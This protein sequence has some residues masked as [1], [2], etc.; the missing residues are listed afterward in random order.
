M[1]PNMQAGSPLI[2]LKG[3]DA[4][5]QIPMLTAKCVA[6]TTTRS[7][8]VLGRSNVEREERMVYPSCSDVRRPRPKMAPL[9]FCGIIVH[10]HGFE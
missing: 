3:N 2:G 4:H 6:C 9:R 8:P 5:S 7:A 10:R 1:W